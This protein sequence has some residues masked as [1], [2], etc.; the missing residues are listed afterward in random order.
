MRMTGVIEDARGL[1]LHDHMCWAYEDLD[2]FRCRVQEFLAEGLEL[3]QRVWYVAPGDV[4]V[5]AN[6]L[7]DLD[8]MNLALRV[9]A[10]Q[11]VSVDT[12]YPAGTVIEPAAQVQAFVRAA[13]QALM[14]GFT[15]LRVGCRHDF[16]SAYAGTARCVCPL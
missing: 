5:L 3:G 14:E 10:A 13:R 9:G 15:G 4:E 2:D 16:A 8:E 7:S 12:A 6:D 11:V 1:G